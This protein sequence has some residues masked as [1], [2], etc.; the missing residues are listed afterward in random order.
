MLT[1]MRHKNI[2]LSGAFD[3]LAH[4]SLRAVVELLLFGQLVV[5]LFKNARIVSSARRADVDAAKNAGDGQQRP[6]A[7]WKENSCG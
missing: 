4:T 1:G 5:Q 3:V 2:R 7:R 6:S